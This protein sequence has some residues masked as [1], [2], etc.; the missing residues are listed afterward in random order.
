MSQWDTNNKGTVSPSPLCHSAGLGTLSDRKTSPYQFLPHQLHTR[1]SKLQLLRAWAVPMELKPHPARRAVTDRDFWGQLLTLTP[2]Q[3]KGTPNHSCQLCL[4]QKIGW[5]RHKRHFHGRKHKY[6][7][8]CFKAVFLNL[9]NIKIGFFK[10][11]KARCFR[12]KQQN[13]TWHVTMFSNAVLP[14]QSFSQFFI[15]PLS[16]QSYPCKQNFYFP[17]RYFPKERILS[18]KSN[19]V[20]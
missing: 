16:T 20:K 10:V 18:N 14:N 12:I 15:C 3:S 8:P 6:S 2:R 7:M 11:S 13:K 17:T 9:K 1:H 5:W 4:H 19:L